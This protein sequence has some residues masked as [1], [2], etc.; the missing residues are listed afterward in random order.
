MMIEFHPAQ[1]QDVVNYWTRI[2]QT[3]EDQNPINENDLSANP[4]YLIGNF[5]GTTNTRLPNP[6][7]S[8]QSIVVPV[9]PVAISEP[10]ANPKTDLEEIAKKDEDSATQADLEIDG[11]KYN[12]K[13]QKFRVD[14]GRFPVGPPTGPCKAAA[15]GYYV[16]I[17]P[18]PPGEHKITFEAQVDN[19][20]KEAPPW[21][22][23]NT[24]TFEV[25]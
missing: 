7:S 21:K 17:D 14:T 18:L 1:K 10:E 23:R 3:P 11:E 4:I 8:K 13:E 6:I 25:R 22:S 19:P 15:D 12:V 24:Y 2:L 5:G 16:V 20:F 9:N